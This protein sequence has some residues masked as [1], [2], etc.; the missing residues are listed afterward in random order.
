MRSSKSTTVL[1]SSSS[2]ASGASA[3]SSAATASSSDDSVRAAA[4]HTVAQ[5]RAGSLA[6]VERLRVRGCDAFTHIHTRARMP[7]AGS[8]VDGVSE[9]RWST[10]Y[11]CVSFTAQTHH[12]VERD[13]LEA[14]IESHPVQ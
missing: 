5:W 12:K 9:S 3:A 1:S 10:S 8:D 6:R 11:V 7:L 4:L 14:D 13:K 2:A